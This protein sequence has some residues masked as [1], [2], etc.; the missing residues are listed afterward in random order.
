MEKNVGTRII[1]NI[2]VCLSALFFAG[3]CNESARTGVSTQRVIESTRSITYY[4]GEISWAVFD[5]AHFDADLADMHGIGA[6]W[7]YLCL[8]G[9]RSP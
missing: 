6:K 5:S 9:M 4:S 7:L 2:L 1:T 8:Y 3:G